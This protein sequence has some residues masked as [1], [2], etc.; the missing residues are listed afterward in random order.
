[1]GVGGGFLA[2]ARRGGRGARRRA[3]WPPPRAGSGW[4]MG[5]CL[6]SGRP[7]SSPNPGRIRNISLI[8]LA[9]FPATMESLVMGNESNREW[10]ANSH[11]P[12]RASRYHVTAL[13]RYRVTTDQAAGTRPREAGCGESFHTLGAAVTWDK[14][15]STFALVR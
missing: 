10:A 7:L 9:G 3:G 4:G 13:P 15:A 11:P 8:L 14:E 2:R 6:D 12:P 1:M 5:G